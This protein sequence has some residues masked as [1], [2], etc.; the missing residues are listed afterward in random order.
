MTNKNYTI[1]M[2]GHIDHGKTELTKALTGVD[3]DRLKEE[4]ERNISIELGYAPLYVGEGLS[5]SIIDVPGHERFIRQ[6][7]A[8]VSGVDATL[9]V[10]AADEGVMP[11]TIEHIEILNYLEIKNAFIVITKVELLEEELLQLVLDDIKAH[12]NNTI[13]KK[14]PTYQVDSLSGKGIEKLKYDLIE[15]LK[16]MPVKDD[17]GY[18]RMPVDQSF[19]VHG[20]GTIVRGTITEG[21]VK[22]GDK[23]L[24]Q[25]EMRETEVKSLQQFGEPVTQSYIGNRTAIA[26]KGMN[27]A[28]IRRGDVLTNNGQYNSSERVDVK[29]NVSPHIKQPIKQRTPIKLHTGTSEIYGRLILFDRNELD[30]PGEDVYV[31]IEL[32]EPAYVIRHDYFILR[33]ATPV[34]TI[35][36]GQVINAPAK[37]HRFGMDTVN[38]LKQ[39]AEFTVEEIILDFINQQYVTR[40]EEITNQLNIDPKFVK[41]TLNQ[42][43]DNQSIIFINRL[44]MTREWFNQQIDSLSITLKDYHD[45][46]PLIVGYDKSELIQ[47]IPVKPKVTKV[48][49]DHLIEQGYFK[50]NAH[51]ISIPDFTPYIPNRIKGEVEE[52]VDN[53]RKDHLKV[54]PFSAYFTDLD[55][56]TI[57][58]LKNY[59]LYENKLVSI[60]DDLFIH[61]VQFDEAVKT[62]KSHTGRQFSLKDAKE[63]LDLSRKYLIP[64]LDKLD[65]MKITIREEEYRCWL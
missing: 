43:Y 32:T 47:Q 14:A 18:F 45:T 30:Q 4:K 11:Q 39:Q 54:D 41:A 40:E 31:Q 16:S 46:R 49:L 6:M 8:G 29:L 20:I 64:F 48:I 53:L 61:R 10:I 34:E 26:L 2:A 22:E 25:P 15:T 17:K 57:S 55:T 51:F 36:G 65:E 37:K 19:H 44:V 35:G 28:L 5:L 63:C 60:T 58:D 50:Q 1:G 33:R 9:L 24:L 62:L 7:I 3:T 12:T 56:E 38:Q 59:L 52:G 23:L 42:L 27:Q 21:V 13:F